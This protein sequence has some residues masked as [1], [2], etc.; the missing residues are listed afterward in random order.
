MQNK[1]KGK[2]PSSVKSKVML[3][4]S[5]VQEFNKVK[6]KSHKTRPHERCKRAGFRSLSKFPI[7]AICQQ[8]PWRDCIVEGV[9]MVKLLFT[10]DVVDDR[11]PAIQYIGRWSPQGVSEEYNSTV[12]A[13]LEDG[14]QA[15]FKF[16]GTSIAVYGTLRSPH[17]PGIATYSVDGGHSTTIRG[18]ITSMVLFRQK[19]YQSP[20]L[21]NGGHILTIT[22]TSE[23]GGYFLDY[24]IITPN[25]VTPQT[26][27]TPRALA[28]TGPL[29]SITTKLPNDS[30]VDQGRP[31]IAVKTSSRT[32]VSSVLTSVIIT[33][34]TVLTSSTDATPPAQTSSLT[35]SAKST[36]LTGI[37]VG[38]SCSAP[39]SSSKQF[40]SYVIAIEFWTRSSMGPPSLP[41]VH[42]T[43]SF[44]KAGLADL[45]QYP[46]SL[47][48]PEMQDITPT[49]D[50]SHSI[51]PT[52]MPPEY[53][54][55]LPNDAQFIG[56]GADLE[57]IKNF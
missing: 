25:D 17:T 45:E 38:D 52:D 36:P 31:V 35:P 26:T 40:S 47:P 18:P 54:E 44:H 37:I 2:E 42:D 10:S 12:H 5:L 4:W 34:S 57:W 39:K 8:P 1:E 28:P 41:V 24:F 29:D 3:G 53:V 33:Q 14:A 7:L 21:G 49:D 56:Y 27:S 48:D 23:G 55:L 16:T 50:E 19:L 43:R 6:E 13:P 32:E 9:L 11:D 15:V 51:A 46:S 30:G 20:Q 22:P